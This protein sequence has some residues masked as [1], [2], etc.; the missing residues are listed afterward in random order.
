MPFNIGDTV[1]D[2]RDINNL[3][4][5]EKHTKKG[6]ITTMTNDYYNITHRDNRVSIVPINLVAPVSLVESLATF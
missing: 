5:T 6:V 2:I 4:V 3:E 1:Y